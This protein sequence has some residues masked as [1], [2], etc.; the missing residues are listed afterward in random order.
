MAIDKQSVGTSGNDTLGGGVSI[1]GSAFSA[2]WRELFGGLGNDVYLIDWSSGATDKVVELPGGGI[3]KVVLVSGVSG[4]ATWTGTSYVMQDQVENLAVMGTPI[5][6][7]AGVQVDNTFG[8][9][10]IIGNNLNNHITTGSGNDTL[11]GGLGA[12]TLLGGGGDD[13]Y[14]VDAVGDIA[15]EGTDPYFL[16]LGTGGNDE[17]LSSVSYTLGSG[18]ENLSLMSA[19]NGINGTGNALNNEIL[20]NAG[21]NVLSGLG[22]DDFLYGGSGRD[23]L[24]GGDG[25][26]TLYGYSHYYVTGDPNYPYLIS[27]N[28]NISGLDGGDLLDGG[29]GNDILFGYLDET[30]L[31]GAGNDILY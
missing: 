4:A 14:L 11:I 2:E 5:L 6:N 13:W 9:I 17:V 28:P 1:N 18:L 12:D 8:D 3:D 30:L 24:L 26:D 29:A 19:A 21:N 22:G 31:G 27:L 25:N 15:V 23:T 10:R 20:G 16:D 7:T